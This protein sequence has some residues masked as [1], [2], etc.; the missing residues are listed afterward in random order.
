MRLSSAA[1]MPWVCR[2]SWA[3]ITYVPTAPSA[4]TPAATE[5]SAATC[6]RIRSLIASTLMPALTSP[7]TRPPSS[8]GVTARTD[9]PRVPV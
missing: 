3:L 7:I 6:S 1:F 8:T 9:G 5:N 4:S 2:R